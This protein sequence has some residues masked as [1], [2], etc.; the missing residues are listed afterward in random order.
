MTITV[1]A[2]KAA[3]AGDI[4][5]DNEVHGLHLRAFPERKSFYLYYRTR[6]GEERRPKLGDASILTL[7]DAR[8]IA[9]DMLVDVAAGKDPAGK[10]KAD[11]AGITINELIDD[12]ETNILPKK[13][14]QASIRSLLAHIRKA[15][16]TRKAATLDITDVEALHT[17][18]GKDHPT[19]A[20]RVVE[21]VSV[22]LTRAERLGARPVGSN[23][24]HLI[25]RNR[26]KK[27]RRYLRPGDEAKAVGAAL[28]A[29]L[30]GPQHEAALFLLL[31]LLTGARKSELGNA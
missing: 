18:I 21:Q 5:R 1:A 25:E 20:N 12:Y 23:F 29:R 17:R 7:N 19:Q 9:R 30:Y 6:A 11:R 26:E 22:L 28:R 13:R 4:L 27:R 31:L 10:W 8:R 16:G 24:C 2:I 15:I 14:S 3:S